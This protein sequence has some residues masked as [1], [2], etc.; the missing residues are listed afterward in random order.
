[1]KIDSLQDFLGTIILGNTIH[2]YFI[3][4]AVFIALTTL[5]SVLG[6]YLLRKLKT[7]VKKTPSRIDDFAAHLFEEMV[8][9]L[10][11]LGAFYFAMTQLV[12][13]SGVARFVHMALLVVLT[14][15]AVR[16]FLKVS[17]YCLEQGWLVKEGQK[18][19]NAASKGVL[20][21]LKIVFWTLALIFILENL[22]FNV[23]AIVA[24]LGIGGIAVALA[25]QTILGDL[26]NYFVIF[27]DKP[28][29][30]GDFIVSGDFMGDIENIG[31]KSTRIRALGG[32]EII[33]SNSNLTASRIH[34]YKRM[35][36]R[37]IE[38]SF[39]LANST[40]RQK[41][42][43]VTAAIKKI[44][45]SMPAVRFDRCH[46]KDFNETGLL[47]E[48]VYIVLDADFNK[49]MDIQQKINLEIRE[50][51]SRESV[52]MASTKPVVQ[53]VDSNAKAA[54]IAAPKISV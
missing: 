45:Q 17:V 34:N 24:G 29:K 32:E 27:F 21:I 6:G 31:I 8:F 33:I 50:V 41:I 22:G 1:M 53:I 49:Y 38:F 54:S 20:T 40:S 19:A 48:M 9:P 23:S 14:V 11:Y 2:N 47:I 16:F 25:C 35:H 28:F 30:E 39:R 12:L 4:I 7:A 13:N 46:F 15:Q 3:A 37:R 5:V 52:E 43:I 10:F 26:F 36:Q 51:L 42:E 18:S 44:I